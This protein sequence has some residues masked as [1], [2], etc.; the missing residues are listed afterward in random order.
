[1]KWNKVNLRAKDKNLPLIGER[2]CWATNQDAPSKNCY[3][4]F[5]GILSNDCK[6]VDTGLRRYKI[7]SNF[8]WVK[9]D[10]PQ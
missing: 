7:T 3:H 9:I 1:M 10:D 6:Y 8:Y 5:F 2:V 4:K